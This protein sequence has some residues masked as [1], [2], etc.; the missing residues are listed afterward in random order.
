MNSQNLAHYKL[1]CICVYFTIFKYIPK[2]ILNIFITGLFEQR[3]NEYFEELNKMKY[4]K[5]KKIV[6][7]IG[8]LIKDWTTTS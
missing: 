3:C 1:M 4:A 5:N 2:I 8:D 6:K 7:Q